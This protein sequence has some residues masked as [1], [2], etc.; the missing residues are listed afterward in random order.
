MKNKHVKSAVN[1][2][3]CLISAAEFSDP[4]LWQFYCFH[5]LCPME[6]VVVHGE[7]AYFVHDPMQ[8]TEI[9]FSACPTLVC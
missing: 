2:F 5:C 3:G 8:L 1:E 9:A 6:L 7:T 4:T